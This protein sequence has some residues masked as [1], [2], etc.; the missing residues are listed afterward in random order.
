MAELNLEI[1]PLLTDVQKSLIELIK[2][3]KINGYVI[4]ITSNESIK[5]ELW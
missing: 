4:E 5:I 3:T 1:K 2:I